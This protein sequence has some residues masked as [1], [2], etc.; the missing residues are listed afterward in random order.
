MN[1]LPKI[2]ETN[3][4]IKLRLFCFPYGGAGTSIYCNWHHY[5]PESI[6]VC[7]IQLPGREERISEKPFTNIVPMIFELGEV[8][9]P[10]LT[11][12]FAFFGHSMGAL[13]SFEFTRYLRKYKQPMPLGLFIS[14]RPAP[15]IKRTESLTYNLSDLEFI[16]KLRQMRGTS[17]TILQNP[18]LMQIFLP[19]LRAD[20]QLCQTY[21]Y[22]HEPPLNCPIFVFGGL[23]DSDVRR[24]ELAC[25]HAQTIH[26]IELHMFPGDHF[27][28]VKD[29]LSLLNII[30]KKLN[31]LIKEEIWNYSCNGEL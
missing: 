30:S 7:P 20:M 29:Q 19:L 23:M 11:Q 15:Q 2:P 4:Q 6:E 3:S 22:L 26:P 16:A 1:Y 13:V 12:P 17:E 8:I 27:F 10:Y 9:K 28:I 18:E 14:G 31:K 5:L 24:E 25:W 21:N